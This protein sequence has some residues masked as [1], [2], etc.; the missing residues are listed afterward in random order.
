V[1]N[2]RGAKQN[3]G[4]KGEFDSIPLKVGSAYIALTKMVSRR[5]LGHIRYNWGADADSRARFATPKEFRANT[6]YLLTD[7]A[8]HE[9]PYNCSIYSDPDQMHKGTITFKGR[10]VSMVCPDWFRKHCMEVCFVQNT[11]LLELAVHG[12]DDP[13]YPD[14]CNIHITPVD[15]AAAKEIVDLYMTDFSSKQNQRKTQ[16]CVPSLTN[17]PATKRRRLDEGSSEA[18]E[19][20]LSVA[21]S[22]YEGILEEIRKDVASQLRQHDN[23]VQK[24]V[25]DMNVQ[26]REDLKQAFRQA[27]GAFHAR[28]VA[29]FKT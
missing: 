2:K 1:P 3:K 25:S 6:R 10:L 17:M 16:R 12:Q 27:V 21:T 5:V 19:P 4:C 18:S 22:S 9:H 13:K 7:D 23:A 28:F 15:P 11:T 8:V 26:L 24:R 20:V 29:S 14:V